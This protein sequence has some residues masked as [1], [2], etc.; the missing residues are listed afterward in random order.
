AVVD[1]MQTRADLYDVLNYHQF[2]AKLDA[3]FT[4]GK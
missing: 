1:S 2:E 3:L 4:D